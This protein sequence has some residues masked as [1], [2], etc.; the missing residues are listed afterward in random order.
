VPNL[1]R[2][3]ADVKSNDLWAYAADSEGS[4]L[5]VGRGSHGGVALVFGAEGRAFGRSY[6]GRATRP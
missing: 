6:A 4:V 3:L 5:D 2:Y 1:A